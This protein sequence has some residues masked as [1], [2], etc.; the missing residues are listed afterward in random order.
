MSRVRRGQSAKPTPP[1]IP[2]WPEITPMI[3]TV[4]GQFR[5]SQNVE[6][7]NQN[8]ARCF[9]GSREFRF[10]LSTSSTNIRLWAFEDGLRWVLYGDGRCWISGEFF[11]DV[12]LIQVIGDRT[13]IENDLMTLRLAL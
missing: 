1:E 8:T 6:S 4:G 11:K 2:L 10:S 12:R 7:I 13:E 5:T 9:V 3:A